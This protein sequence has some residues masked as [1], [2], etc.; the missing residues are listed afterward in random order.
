MSNRP[1]TLLTAA[2]VSGALA[3]PLASPAA[4]ATPASAPTSAAAAPGEPLNYVALGDSFAAAPLVL[5]VDTSNVLCL[6][7]RADYP[8]IAAEALGA[9]L[10]DVSCSAAKVEDLTTS[11]HLGTRP[12]YEALS[13]QTDVVSITIGGNDTG[14]VG[15]ALGCVN[16]LP[17]PTGTSCAARNTEGGTDQLKEGIDAWAPKFGAALKEIHRRAPDADVFV[18]G[19]GNYIRPGGC[20]PA[21]P[22][23]SAD[24]DYIQGT[25]DHLGATLERTA[26]EHGASFVDTYPL[27]VGHDACAAPADRYTEG[28]VPTH[29]AAPLHPNA[30]GSEAVGRALAAAVRAT[31]TATTAA[32]AATATG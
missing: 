30:K 14:L 8:H 26:R 28:L 10:T 29:A 9:E 13:A 18:V 7:S 17:E 24:A 32:T 23:W 12:Q 27:G 11:Q 16:L 21:Q 31:T 25:V 19:Y 1:R 22:F 15:A 3:V 5:P 4:S 2:I 20:F 6:R